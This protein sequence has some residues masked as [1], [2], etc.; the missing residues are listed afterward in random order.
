MGLCLKWRLQL[1]W[2]TELMDRSCR[3]DGGSADAHLVRVKLPDADWHSHQSSDSATFP[4]Q[5]LFICLMACVFQPAA[6]LWCISEGWWWWWWEGN[7]RFMD[8]LC[9]CASP[10]RE[11]FF[12][13]QA[14]WWQRATSLT[15]CERRALCVVHQTLWS[16]QLDAYWWFVRG[17]INVDFGSE[18]EKDFKKKRKKKRLRSFRCS[19]VNL[20]L[21]DVGLVFLCLHIWSIK[22]EKNPT[23]VCVCVLMC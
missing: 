11:P 8:V 23:C 12:C 9:Y 7:G 18:K 4:N 16:W 21:T 19:H 20:E 3:R 14:A 5:L 17:E 2:H 1:K 15:V 13:W 10:R 6:R 22:I